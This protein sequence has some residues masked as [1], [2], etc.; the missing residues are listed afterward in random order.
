[1]KK[2]ENSKSKINMLTRTE[3]IKSKHKNN[4]KT[5]YKINMDMVNCITSKDNSVGIYFSLPTSF[6]HNENRN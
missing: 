1:M 5:S 2:L 6:N 3:L 4:N